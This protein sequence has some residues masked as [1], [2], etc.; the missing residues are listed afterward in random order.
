[1]KEVTP[2]EKEAP[3][4]FGRVC[5]AFCIWIWNLRISYPAEDIVLA[6][7]DILSCFCWTRITPDLVEAF[8]FVVG[9]VFFTANAMVFGCTTLVSS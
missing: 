5:L 9:T 3:I 6:F 8:G 4:T 7:I 2:I 1:M